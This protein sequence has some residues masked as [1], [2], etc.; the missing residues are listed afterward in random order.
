MTTKPLQSCTRKELAEM[1]R[2]QG[3]V[4]WHSM[5]KDELISALS[6]SPK[7][8]NGKP[9]PSNGHA[10]PQKAAARNTSSTGSAEEEVESAKF[11]VGVPTRELSHRIPRDLPTHYGKDRI[12]LMVRDP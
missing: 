2:E 10:H 1:A 9:K 3:I 11:D 8:R 6:A 4:G 12:V 7:K 5:R